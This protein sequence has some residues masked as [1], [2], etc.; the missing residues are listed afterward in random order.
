MGTQVGQPKDKKGNPLNVDGLW[1]LVFGN[2]CNNAA[3]DLVVFHRGP[4]HGERGNLRQVRRRR[5]RNPKAWEAA[6]VAADFLT[7]MPE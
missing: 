7:E 3:T 1:A 4:E 5:Q 2:G 6:E